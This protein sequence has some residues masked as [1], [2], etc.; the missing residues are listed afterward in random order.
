MSSLF[1]SREGTS[2]LAV[3]VAAVGAASFAVGLLA[4]PADSRE[5]C[6]WSFFALVSYRRGFGH[7]VVSR[8]SYG[9]VQVRRLAELTSVT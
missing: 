5:L 8:L 3:A 2:A 4:R 6:C 7:L 9:L 1:L